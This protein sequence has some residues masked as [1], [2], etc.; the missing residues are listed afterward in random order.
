MND[1]PKK[2]LTLEVVIELFLWNFRYVILLGVAGLLVGSLVI[3]VVGAA[4]TIG[5]VEMAISGIL[6]EGT[7]LTASTYGDIIVKVILC[8]D[9][10]LLGI[11]LLVFGLGTYD[12]FVSR[13]DPA[14]EQTDVRPH[15]LVFDSLDELKNVLGRVTL[16]ILTI[17]FLRLVVETG[18]RDIYKDPIDVALLGG[19]I[20]FVAAAIRL[21]QGRDID[22]SRAPR[23]SRRHDQE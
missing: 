15:W 10:F 20:L 9:D 11:V 23:P 21:S 16:M 6:R 17:N 4:S 8:I 3:F 13:I 18:A 19:A 22:L 1:T 14:T 12:L 5:V 2:K 7:H